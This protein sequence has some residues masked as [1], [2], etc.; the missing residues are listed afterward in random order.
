MEEELVKAARGD[1]PAA[2]A[3]PLWISVAPD[4]TKA[5]VVLG[6]NGEPYADVEEVQCFKERGRWHMAS[7]SNG[8]G[9]G[10]TLDTW[11]DDGPCL[12]LLQLGGEAPPEVE[13][14]VVRWD[15]QDH[16]V[17]VVGGYFFFGVWDVPE[18]FAGYPE[19][20]RYLRGDGSSEDV[21]RD[22]AQE[23]AWQFERSHRERF[24]ADARRR[25]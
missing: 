8:V 11:V 22:P 9:F 12:G 21:P 7:S 4:G 20:I 14:V 13:A 17:R 18:D 10:W 24:M 3:D 25:R 19:V 23:R 6:I 2:Y 1:I 16:L 15:R 5:V